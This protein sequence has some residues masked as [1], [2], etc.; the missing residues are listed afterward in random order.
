MPSMTRTAAS[1][2]LLLPEET[3]TT[4]EKAPRIR[5]YRLARLRVLERRDASADRHPHL[6]RAYD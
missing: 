5:R 2:V 1:R 4:A 3:A 6:L